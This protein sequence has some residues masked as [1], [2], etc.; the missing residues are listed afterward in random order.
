[1]EPTHFRDEADLHLPIDRDGLAVVGHRLGHDPNPIGSWKRGLPGPAKPAQRGTPR[2]R[3][4]AQQ[5]RES[6]TVTG[7]LPPA[8]GRGKRNLPGFEGGG[9]QARQ[10]GPSAP[11][12]RVPDRG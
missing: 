2:N 8:E 11:A 9:D 12:M 6:L 1:M 7:T 5:P 3:N 10:T 4:R